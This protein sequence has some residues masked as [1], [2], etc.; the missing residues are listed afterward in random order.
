V[1]LNKS[2]GSGDAENYAVLTEAKLIGE[3]GQKEEAKKKIEGVISKLESGSSKTHLEQ[4][5]YDLSSYYNYW[6][7]Y[8]KKVALVEKS[9][10]IYKSQAASEEKAVSLKMLGDLY[11][12][13]GEFPKG[14]EQL[15][16]AE[17]VYDSIKSRG[18]YG[19]YVLFA[20]IYKFLG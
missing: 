14:I 6:D 5:Y 9:V 17:A 20:Q 13:N 8:D 10:A 1:R 19:V 16:L 4:A 18:V 3:K 12:L 7:N 15:K 2:I 11:S